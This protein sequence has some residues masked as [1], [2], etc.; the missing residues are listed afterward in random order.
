MEII[1]IPLSGALQHKDSMGNGTVIESGD[2]QAMSAGTGI[3]HSEYNAHQTETVSLLQ[4]WILPNIRQVPP[5]YQQITLAEKPINTLC[6]IV[7]PMTQKTPN[8]IGIH[9]NAHFLLGK[10][11]ANQTCDYRMQTPQNGVYVF[12]ISGQITIA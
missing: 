10:F 11:T 8:T 3:V 4:I 2:I 6:A 9:Q 1:T 5:Q 7:S 12:V